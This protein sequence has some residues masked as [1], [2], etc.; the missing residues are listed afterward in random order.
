MIRSLILLTAILTAMLCHAQ[1]Q[2]A[3]NSIDSA[4]FYYYGGSPISAIAFASK[5]RNLND[6]LQCLSLSIQAFSLFDQQSFK[7]SESLLKQL[8]TKP[9]PRAIKLPALALFANLKFINNKV[10]SAVLI[11]NDAIQEA[12]L[13]PL[14]PSRDQLLASLYLNLGYFSTP[15]TISKNYSDFGYIM[16]YFDN[17]EDYMKSSGVLNGSL[18]RYLYLYRALAYYNCGYKADQVSINLKRAYEYAIPLADEK[19]FSEISGYLFYNLDYIEEA[20]EFLKDSKLNPWYAMAL[21]KSDRI[22]EGL[23]LLD[24]IVKSQESHP[25]EKSEAYYFLSEFYLQ[26]NNVQALEYFRLAKEFESQAIA[27]EYNIYY[28]N[29]DSNKDFLNEKFNTVLT[30][31]NDKKANEDMLF[32]LFVSIAVLSVGFITFYLIFRKRHNTGFERK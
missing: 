2:P 18:Y 25:F 8:L 21:I 14:G 26:K 6:S 32:I 22:E 23:Q 28:I 24:D 16:G 27:L 1:Q 13:A 5:S 9:C 19:G 30:K 12:R 15:R 10:D 3:E 29:K 4:L 7:Q 31:L 20:V 11:T 17:A